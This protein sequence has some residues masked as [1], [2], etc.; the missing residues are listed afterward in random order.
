MALLALA[1]PPGYQFVASA[2]RGEAARLHLRFETGGVAL[3]VTLVDT[4]GAAELPTAAPAGIIVAPPG[5]ELL[6]LPPRRLADLTRR[7]QGDDSLVVVALGGPAV[8]ALVTQLAGAGGRV[9]ALDTA[10]DADPRDAIGRVIQLWMTQ[11]DHAG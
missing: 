1:S 2:L 10:L 11:H 4:E 7:V 6:A 3:V 8:H 9:Q 5:G